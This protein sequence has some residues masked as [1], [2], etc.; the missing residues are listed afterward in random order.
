MTVNEAS[1]DWSIVSS[2][3]LWYSLQLSYD[4]DMLSIRKFTIKSIE[5]ENIKHLFVVNFDARHRQDIFESKGDKLSS[6]VEC[7]LRTLKVWDNKSQA[8]S[9]HTHKPTEPSGIKLKIMKLDRPFLW[10]PSVQSTWLHCRLTFAPG[11]SIIRVCWIEYG[12]IKHLFVVNCD[13]LAQGSDFRIE[14][15]QVAFLC[16]VQDSKR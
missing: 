6:S 10:W 3:Y 13:A 1:A 14:R 12:N 8:D 2:N 5:Y 7:R 9:M 11:S 4:E 15:R 16:W